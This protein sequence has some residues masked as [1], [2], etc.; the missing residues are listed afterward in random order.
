VLGVPWRLRF[1]AAESLESDPV[2][3]L[4]DIV[5]DLFSGISMRRLDA[6]AALESAPK[7]PSAK[8]YRKCALCLF[9]A[10]AF[11]LL[12]ASLI[13]SL[14]GARAI[15]NPFGWSGFAC[16][17]GSILCVIRYAAVNKRVGGYSGC[18]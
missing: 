5:T 1:E 11:L 13:D 7:N 9:L 3:F 16:V 8:R 4:L 10:A 2:E 18:V 17:Q 12:T 6:I 14:A 15:A